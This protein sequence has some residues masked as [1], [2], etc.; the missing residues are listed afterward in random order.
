MP[1]KS[2]TVRGYGHEHQERRRKLAVEVARRTVN[3]ARCG[4]PIR[5][6]TEWDLDHDD[7]DRGRYLG[8]SHANCNRGARRNGDVP[9]GVLES[10]EVVPDD[11][12]RGQ[13]YGP[14]CEVGKPLLRWSRAWFTWRDESGEPL[15]QYRHLFDE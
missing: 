11:P 12:E 3:C 8:P 5:P 10:V 9:A 1:K 7:A 15:P 6:G 4:K 13:Y 2:T 14:P